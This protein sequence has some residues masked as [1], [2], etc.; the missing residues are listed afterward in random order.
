MSGYV[1]EQLPEEFHDT[2]LFMKPCDGRH[3]RNH[4]ETLLSKP[5]G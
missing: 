1:R 5:F 2:P 3:L 4:I